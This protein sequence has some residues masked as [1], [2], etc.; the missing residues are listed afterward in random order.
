MLF[1]AVMATFTSSTFLIIESSYFLK[2][3]FGVWFD[4]DVGIEG[5][6]E[7]AVVIVGQTRL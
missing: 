6:V 7:D 4:D 2:S 5:V 3:D 1:C